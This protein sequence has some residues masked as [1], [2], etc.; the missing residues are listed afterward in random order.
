M[1]IKL[2]FRTIIFIFI[3]IFNYN[4]AQLVGSNM[5]VWEKAPVSY[6]NDSTKCRNNK[7][8]N[9]NCDIK[10]KIPVTIIKYHKTKS[11]SLVAVHTSGDNEWIWKNQEN[12]VNLANN[13]YQ[14]VKVNQT[15]GINKRPSLY[16]FVSPPVQNDSLTVDSLKIKF[17]DKNLYEIIFTPKKIRPSELRKIQ[18]YLSIKYGISLEEGKYYNSSN[19]IIWDPGKHKNFKYR[20]T[21][22]GRDDGNELY[23]KQSSNQQDKFLIIGK[24]QIKRLN[25]LNTA[26]L[27]N[28]AFVIWSDDNKDMAFENDGNYDVLKRNWEINFIG[29]IE[30]NNYKIRIDKTVMNPQSFPVSYW[31]FLKKSDGSIQK[32]QGVENNNKIVFNDII[33]DTDE[34]NSTTFTFAKKSLEGI[35]KNNLD[36]KNI[37]ANASVANA[38]E[39]IL[40]PNPVKMNETFTIEFPASK[41]MEISIYDG[42]GRLLKREFIDS[43]ATQYKNH[44]VVQGTYIIILNQNG[45][46]IKIFKLIVQ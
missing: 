24:N 39:I 38:Q 14:K 5:Q 30:K 13:K 40:Y 23:Q 36:S 15:V 11:H 4:N 25:F 12:K 2:F 1:M 44:L 8:L 10:D 45:Q 31:I 27:N 18:S 29:Q 46:K 17:E 26:T 42:G 35:E 32:I 37:G 19:D 3:L 41:G 6:V 28:K 7:L 20:P 22:I 43:N 9:F 34:N 21:G 16:S 33:F